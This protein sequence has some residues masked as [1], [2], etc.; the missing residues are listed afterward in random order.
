MI[1]LA[2]ITIVAIALAFIVIH[3][4][5]HLVY[6]NTSRETYL[7]YR[8]YVRDGYRKFHKITY[9]KKLW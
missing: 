6:D 8:R 5:A 9:C 4:D 3:Y 2:I 1:T 7:C